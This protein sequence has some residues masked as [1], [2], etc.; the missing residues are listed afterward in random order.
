MPS[1]SAATRDAIPTV[2]AIPARDEADRIVRCL[3][4]LRAQ[5]DV[6]GER[7]GPRAPLKI[8]VLINN[9]RDDTAG[10]IRD[11]RERTGAAVAWRETDLG[12][13][14]HAGA[15]RRAAMDWGLEELAAWGGEGVICTTDADSVARPDWLAETW[16]AFRVGADAVAGVV[17]FD[18]ERLGGLA[19]SPLRRLEARFA[20]LQ[21]EMIARADPQPHDPWPN[22][23]WAWGA[24]LAV[25][26]DAYRAVGG[27]PA[28]PLA[29]DR[30]F[31][32]ALAARDLRLRHA[33]DVRVRTSV[34]NAGRAPGGLADLI[35]L[36]ARG[37]DAAPC[38]VA[39]EATSA[40]LERASCRRLLR[41][42]REAAPSETDRRVRALARRLGVTRTTVWRALDQPWFG[43]G[44]AQLEAS[45][46]A[47][48]RRR[49][50]PSDLPREI[51]LA[52]Q[53]LRATKGA[54]SE[55]HR[56]DSLRAASAGL[57]SAP[58]AQFE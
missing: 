48:E 17:E 29:E 52:E 44:W 46:P 55:A 3:D 27:L 6:D 30:A 21:A 39:L 36:Y 51:Y 15:A 45:S 43:V 4:A 9:T 49:L 47:L 34:R 10:R 31:A 33:L 7:L 16:K 26:A 42:L 35:S 54:A 22:H 32:A 2:V 57:W 11:W 37:D 50:F 18:P 5:V 13:A 14:V 28:A 23:I 25:T 12:G 20:A 24:S 53:A 38:D 19:L 40:T 58:V 41:R 1:P 56:A 8:V